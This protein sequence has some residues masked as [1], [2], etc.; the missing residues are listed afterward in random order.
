MGIKSLIWELWILNGNCWQ[1]I[2]DIK[3][4]SNKHVFPKSR[5]ASSI[6][7]LRSENDYMTPK[8]GFLSDW[9]WLSL[10]YS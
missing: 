8:P 10:L 7:K 4:I 9:R 5:I 6:L 3:N 2:K 1:F